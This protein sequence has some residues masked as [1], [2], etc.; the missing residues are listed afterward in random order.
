M[1]K[2]LVG[3]SLLTLAVGF[4]SLTAKASTTGFDLGTGTSGGITFTPTGGGNQSM[5]LP[6]TNT[7]TA[8]GK[9][10]LLG[11]HGFYFLSGGPVAL[12]DVFNFPPLLIAFYTASGT[13]NFEID[14]NSTDT[15]TDL[16]IGTLTL[17]N[18]AQV[19]VNDLTKIF[20]TVDMHVTGGTDQ[21]AFGNNG[22]ARF[23]I[24]LIGIG[25]L[26][27]ASGPTTARFDHHSTFLGSTIDVAPEP[28]SML[29]FGSGLLA[30]TIMLRRKLR[31]A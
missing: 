19:G 6:V 8:T 4:T 20:A 18:L 25:Y 26:P 27:T 29:L 17:V 16:L 23:R 11:T 9:G 30:I 15:G 31:V 24:D 28:T 7:G 22:N 1:R 13:L 3:L 10:S 21:A 5:S 12:T 2:L 14:A